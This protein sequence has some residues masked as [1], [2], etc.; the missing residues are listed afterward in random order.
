MRLRRL[1]SLMLLAASL[2]ACSQEIETTPEQRACI[3]GRYASYDAKKI[4]QCVAAEVER[5][6]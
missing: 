4:D 5:N 6:W 2:A 1:F 3:A